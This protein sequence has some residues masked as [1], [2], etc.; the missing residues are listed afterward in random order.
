MVD[1]KS[2]Q[3]KTIDAEKQDYLEPGVQGGRQRVAQFS[4][5]LTDVGSN[6]NAF[7]IDLPPNAILEEVNLFQDASDTTDFNIGDANSLAAIVDG[8]P[9][10]Q[11]IFIR[12]GESE[13]SGTNGLSQDDFLKPL[14]E[15]L[16][17]SS[18]EAAGRAIRLIATPVGTPGDNMLYGFIRYTID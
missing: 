5:D 1:V 4:V 12:A 18:R 3:L 7:L 6:E 11:E 9:I 2:D 14:W 10:N 16:G 15:V 13:T 8:L 17:Y